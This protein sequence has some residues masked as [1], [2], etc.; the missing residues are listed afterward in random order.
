MP[1]SGT[2]D[3]AAVAPDVPDAG[4][5]RR[6]HMGDAPTP[7]SSRSTGRSTTPARSTSR[8]RRS[9]RRSRRSPRS[10]APASPRHRSGPSPS[11][12]CASWCGPVSARGRSASARC[13][14]RAAAADALRAHWGYPV[15]LG[16]VEA[17]RRHDQVR[18]TALARRPHRR[19]RRRA[20]GGRHQ[21]RRPHD[22][23]QPA[24]GALRRE[25]GGKLVQV[26]PE[27]TIHQADRGRPRCT[28]PTRRP[29]ACR[30]GCSWRRPSSGS[31]SGPTPTSCRPGSSLTACSRRAPAPVG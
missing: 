3:V 15:L 25:A 10:S 4:R 2:L 9:T 28:S 11:C 8:R 17:P 20:H 14:T 22:L 31:H 23:R 27:Y 13:A 12:R 30:A 26:D 24:P 16:E 29:S 1:R 6:S 21:R 7:S 18:F 19:R 5:S